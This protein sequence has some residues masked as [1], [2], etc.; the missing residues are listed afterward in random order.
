MTCLLISLLL[1]SSSLPLAEFLLALAELSVL[2]FLRSEA[3]MELAKL[4][5][6]CLRPIGDS[7]SYESRM[8]FSIVAWFTDNLAIVLKLTFRAFA[9]I[10][11]SLC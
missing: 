11:S 1:L 6:F 8:A 2:V 4:T 5:L 3:T 7:R 9:P 10:R